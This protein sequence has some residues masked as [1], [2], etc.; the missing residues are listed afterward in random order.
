MLQ[1]E[2]KQLQRWK[3][4]NKFEGIKLFENLLVNEFLPIDQQLQRENKSLQHILN[5]ANQVIPYYQD[6]FNNLS[7][8]PKNINCLEKLTKLPLLTKHDLYKFQKKLLVTQLPVNEKIYGWFSSS[9][10]TGRPAKVLMT[11]RSNAMFAILAHRNWRWFRVD[12]MGKLATIRLPTQLPRIKGLVIPDGKALVL[13]GWRYISQYFYTGQGIFLNVTNSVEQ[14]ISLLKQYTPDYLMAYSES[15]EHLSYAVGKSF[16]ENKISGLFSISEQL[17]TAM[18]TRIERVFNAPI[19]Q[20]YG[21]NEIGLVATMCQAGRYHVHTEHCL[22]EIISE[23]GEPCK[24]GETGRII[25]TALTN[26]AMPLIRYDTD[27]LAEAVDRNCPCGRTLPAFG[28]VVGRYSR[29]AYLPEATLGQVGILQN[30]VESITDELAKNLRQFQIYQYTDDGGF[31]LRLVCNGNLPAGFK[32]HILKYWQDSGNGEIPL[33][34]SLVDTIP[35][36]P[37]GKHQAFDS[38]YYPTK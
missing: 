37:G 5:Y 34:F 28:K 18:R 33:E 14:Q 22:V 7:L 13:P 24:P 20:N 16:P 35:R 17:T 2:Q 9:G 1:E 12:P 29:I 6:I 10:T 8:N 19:Q 15:L 30:A 31:Q 25:V 38:A 26:L 21:L 32:K 3:L 27:D 36:S 11:Q 23:S 4:K